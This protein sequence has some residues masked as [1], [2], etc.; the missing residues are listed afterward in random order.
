MTD[1]V[2][3][4]A[5]FMRRALALAHRAGGEVRPN[6][7]VGAVVVQGQEVVGEGYHARCGGPHAERIA[8]EVAG[9]RARAAELFV[10]LEPCSHH[11]RTPPCADAVI[12]GG[13][14]R[15][16]YGTRDPNP[17]VAGRGLAALGRAGI[18]VV[19][20]M[21]EAECRALA[22]PFIAFHE[23]G[24]PYTIL[25]WAA[26]LD[27]KLATRE[28][29]SRWITGEESRALV[30]ALRARV[31]AVVIGIG[32]ALADDPRL[33][34]RGPGLEHATQPLRVVVDSACRIPLGGALVASARASPVAV[35]CLVGT[36]PDR[37]AALA[38]A[39]AEPIPCPARDGRVDLEALWTALGARG[40]QAA[41]V[42][43]G[44]T[45]GA[46]LV[47]R[48]LVDVVLAFVAPLLIGGV[49]APGAVG[50]AGAAALA[51]APRW[52]LWECARI[53]GDALLVAAPERPWDL[54]GRLVP[55]R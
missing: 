48:G 2:A 52:T 13:V 40:I 31:D 30:H 53:G 15:V 46:G 18:E 29:D 27:G 4:D 10:T 19:G 8:L 45:L 38:L 49:S 41:L 35:A 17:A 23:R 43:G 24:R 39:G 32:T 26:S 1:P 50:G 25:K 36:A 42:E 12:A 9:A 7:P 37:V 21:L 28:G 44:A 33:T 47:E 55:A 51:L 20:P 54:L 3:R 6:P 14:R 11:G 16:V 34:A 22:R 5:A